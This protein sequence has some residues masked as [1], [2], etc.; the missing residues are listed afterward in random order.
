MLFQ[1]VCQDK[2]RTPDFLNP[3]T[4]LSIKLINDNS[5][6]NSKESQ[7]RISSVNPDS[8]IGS[9]ICQMQFLEQGD[10]ADERVMP[11]QKIY[12]LLLTHS[13]IKLR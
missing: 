9:H 12:P 1:S 8:H 5:M 6:S 2:N 13:C 11:S 3:F 10:P 7:G 4:H